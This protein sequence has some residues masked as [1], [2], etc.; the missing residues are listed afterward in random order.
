MANYIVE[1][2]SGVH[3]DTSAAQ[4]AITSAGASI[5]TTFSLSLTF[6]IS[7]T[8]EQ[9]AAISGVKY[10]EDAD[11]DSGLGL[12]NYS[13]H[14]FRYLDN[15]YYNKAN[16]DGNITATYSFS[17]WEPKFSGNGKTV[18]LI[19]SGIN[20]GHIEFANATITN[21]HSAYGSTF[22]DSTGHGT[23]MAGLIVG[24]NI[25]LA[26]N[27]TIKNVKLFDQ[28]SGNISVGNVITA[29]DAVLSDHNGSNVA[30]VKVLCAPWT[31]AQNN[32]IDSKIGEIN[33]SNIVVVAA[34]GNNNDNVANY[35]PA[36]VTDI[37][38]VGAHD[39]EFVISEFTNTAWDGGSDATA[40]PNYGAAVDIFTIGENVTTCSHLSSVIYGRATGT[41]MSTALVAGGVAQYIEKHP[42]KS[43]NQIKDTLIAEGSLRGKLR[44][45]L[46]A[47]TTSANLDLINESVLQLD[48]GGA[49]ESINF[50]NTFSSGR[51]LNVQSGTTANIN[52]DINS[53]LSNVSIL[54]FSP[55]APWMSFDA[56]T[57]IVTADAS[58]LDANLSPGVFIFGIRGKTAGDYVVV[59]EFSVGV[60]DSAE[61]EL[62]SS[63]AYY[64]DSDN[65]E[66]DE[67]EFVTYAVAGN[68]VPT[69][70]TIK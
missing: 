6:L 3:A 61:S 8:A 55:L 46:G 60:Y 25:G 44:L 23:S 63:T 35:S 58:S 68:R 37:I 49:D 7:A 24:E 48:S 40:F 27:S 18:Y 69:G 15:R 21:L 26:R 64:Y 11:A 66:Y 5:T 65:T 38:T 16:I 52:L 59:E 54:P 67:A 19:D 45:T 17:S 34:A 28:P 51:I 20:A 31:T 22:S 13:T 39:N 12:Q 30:D 42:G 53:T 62:E 14:H 4:S 43:S 29:L 9:L 70:V 41:S 50:S 56:N 36:G 32:L 57:G 33:N 2:D 47:G 1:M 10:S